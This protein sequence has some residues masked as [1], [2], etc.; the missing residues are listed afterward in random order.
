MHKF[1][2]ILVTVI[3]IMS[4]A[5]GALASDRNEFAIMWIGTINEGV[6]PSQAD[7]LISKVA[8]V[9][10]NNTGTLAFE[11]SR[12][13]DQLFGYE[14]FSDQQG[15]LA[16]MELVGPFYPQIGATWATITVVPTTEIPAEV[17]ELLKGYN[18]LVPDSFARASQ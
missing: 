10:S 6:E 14:R 4:A 11:I 13:G 12:V 2:L 1:T 18:A 8:E 15:L 5:H 3:G 16:Q 7:E 9:V 17:A